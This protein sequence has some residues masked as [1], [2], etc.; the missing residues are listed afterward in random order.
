MKNFFIQ[1]FTW[2]NGATVA[3]RFH[4]WRHGEFVGADEFGN[5]YYQTKGG[6][7]DPALGFVR[8]WVIYNGVAEASRIPPG[9]Y[10]WMLQKCDVPP[11]R[12]EA[13]VPREW[14]RP[15][16]PN[17]TGTPLAY[18]PKGSILRGEPRAKA[19]D[20]YQPWTPGA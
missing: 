3:T 14:E 12:D 9:W 4:T 17:P 5:R 2:W 6:K 13:Y 11:S 8:R 10:G 19:M 18:R 15:H 20:G 1:F 16:Q 7:K